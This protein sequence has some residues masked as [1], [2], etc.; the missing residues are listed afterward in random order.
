MFYTVDACLCMVERGL[1]EIC[2]AFI[3]PETFLC[4][5]KMYRCAHE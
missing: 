4:D 2:Y 1:L 5:G 3:M